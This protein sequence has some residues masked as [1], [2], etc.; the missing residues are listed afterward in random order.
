MFPWLAKTV[1]GFRWL[2]D[3]RKC[4][5][6]R[7]WWIYCKGHFRFTVGIRLSPVRTGQEKYLK[8]Y[9]VFIEFF[10]LHQSF[11]CNIPG[12]SGTIHRIRPL[13]KQIQVIRARSESIAFTSHL[14]RM[15]T[16]CYDTINIIA[17]TANMDDILKFICIKLYFIVKA[18]LSI[19]KL[20]L[21]FLFQYRRVNNFFL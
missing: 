4:L 10:L 8:V 15:Q 21:L 12:S 5:W 3:Y 6:F 7:L 2:R 11:P 1:R 20:L 9:N 19:I 16:A 13:C 14:G 17:I 18:L